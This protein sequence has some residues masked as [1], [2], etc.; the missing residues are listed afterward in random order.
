MVSLPLQGQG[1][2]ERTFLLFG[3]AQMRKMK[4]VNVI[5]NQIVVDATTPLRVF[6]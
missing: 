1:G 2:A 5:R 6:L 3:Q 4:T